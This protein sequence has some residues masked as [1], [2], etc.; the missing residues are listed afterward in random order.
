MKDVKIVF[1]GDKSYIDLTASVEG[2]VNSEQKCLVN[3]VTENGSDPIYEDRGT[4]LLADSINGLAYDRLEAIHVANFA[5]LDTE[6]FMSDV[7]YVPEGEEVTSDE[8]NEDITEDE[9]TEDTEDDVEEVEE[10]VTDD[11]WSINLTPVEVDSYNSNMTITVQI[12][13]S[14]DTTTKSISTIP[15]TM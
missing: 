12:T 9:D 7:K 14:D 3:L 11:I 13:F 6:F 5:A 2:K 1:N 15:I 4:T 8:Y 10:P